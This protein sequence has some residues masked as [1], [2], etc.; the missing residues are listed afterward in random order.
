MS[1]HGATLFPTIEAF[2][3][4][5]GGARILDLPIGTVG[6]VQSVEGGRDGST[7]LVTS[8]VE[9]VENKGKGWYA[10]RVISTDSPYGSFRDRRLVWG[11]ELVTA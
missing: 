6:K 5:N 10:T 2:R 3:A 4:R 8:E 7:V 1:N 11:G 9:V